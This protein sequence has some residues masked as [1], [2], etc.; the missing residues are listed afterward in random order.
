MDNFLFA[1]FVN[2][3]GWAPYL[4]AFGVLL[5][6]GMGF[7][8]PEDITLFAMGY[9]AY[10][11]LTDLKVSAIVCLFGVLA[12]DCCV[13]GMGRRYGESLINHPHLAKLLHAERMWHARGL[14]HRWGT[15]V[16]FAARFMPGLRAPVFF[17]AGALKLPFRV[18]L[19]FDGLAAV[20]SVPLLLGTTWYFGDEIGQAITVAERVQFGVVFLILAVVAWLVLRHFMKRRRIRST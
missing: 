10:L 4:I 15:R 3:S 17:S 11:E 13:Y 14:F 2:S 6:C 16:I 9:L 20:I 18:F 1:F 7:P 5:A 12:G 8:I 19:F